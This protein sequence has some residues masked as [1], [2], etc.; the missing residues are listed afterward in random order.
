MLDRIF[1]CCLVAPSYAGTHIPMPDR[2][3]PHC[4]VAPAPVGAL[5]SRLPFVLLLSLLFT[6]TRGIFPCFERDANLQFT[7]LSLS[8]SCII[9]HQGIEVR[10]TKR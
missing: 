8:G 2:I 10:T 7:L 3:A 4:L 6:I 9:T 5:W 1:F